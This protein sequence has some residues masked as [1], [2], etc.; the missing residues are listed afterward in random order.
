MLKPTESG[1]MNNNRFFETDGQ[2]REIQDIRADLL[3]I[4]KA[5]LA[6]ALAETDWQVVRSVDPSSGKPLIESVLQE[7]EL[8][9]QQCDQIESKILAA[10]SYEELFVIYQ[11]HFEPNC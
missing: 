7:R 8:S 2:P 6:A 10:T 9:R 4:N 1:P 11:Q 3:L 5:Y